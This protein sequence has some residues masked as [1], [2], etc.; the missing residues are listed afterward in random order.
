MPVD[1]ITVMLV[2]DDN[3]I[4]Q[5]VR[6][7]L[8]NMG[9]EVH[10]FSDSVKALEHIENGCQDCRLVVSD[11]RMPNI[12]GFQLVRRIR[13]LRPEM[14]TMLMTAFDVNMTEFRAVFPSL[15]VDEVVRKPF[16]PSRLAEKINEVLI[17]RSTD[18][19]GTS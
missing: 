12:N 11:I 14:K 4:L 15:H 16:L 8:E 7:G 3:D 19:S 5:S 2:D 13:E 10:G 9:F 17:A 18:P 6:K 1:K